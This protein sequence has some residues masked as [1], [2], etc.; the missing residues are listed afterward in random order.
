MKE[1]KDEFRIGTLAQQLDVKRFVIRFWEKEFDIPSHRSSGGQRFYKAQD[2]EQF[3]LIKK[4][5][6]EKGFT[7]SGAKKVLKKQGRKITIIG[8]NRAKNTPKNLHQKMP[9][10][11]SEQ[12]SEQIIALQKK[13]IKLRN[14]L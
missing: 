7:I 13:L 6:Y 2:I 11:K 8:S 5:L 3:K 9:E 14:L 4:L 10:K 1:H 12:I